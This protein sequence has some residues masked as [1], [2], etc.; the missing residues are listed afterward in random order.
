MSEHR[1]IGELRAFIKDKTINRR[2][3]GTMAE[4]SKA[5]DSGSHEPG[6]I[7]VLVMNMDRFAT[8]Q[9]P[10]TQNNANAV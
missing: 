5:F 1:V 2:G 4:R 8:L 6:S 3:V 10:A 9:I 7:P